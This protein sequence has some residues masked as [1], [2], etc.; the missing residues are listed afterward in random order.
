MGFGKKFINSLY[1]FKA[2]NVFFNHSV[3]KG[4]LYLFLLCLCLSTIGN[5]FAGFRI[6]TA[7]NTAQDTI[8]NNMPDF[9]FNNG[10][11]SVDGEMPIVIHENKTIFYI[12]TE[13]DVD[14]S[15]L[16]NYSDGILLTKDK[17]IQKQNNVQIQ[18]LDLKQMQSFSFNK[19]DISPAL[20]GIKTFIII[21]RFIFYPL[22][23]FIGKLASSFV[24]MG[25]GGLILNA[26]LNKKLKYMDCVKLGMYSLTV[27][28][29]LNVIKGIIG[30]Q[31]S[32]FFI[33]YYG[34]ALLYLFLGMKEIE[35]T[36]N[37]N[38]PYEQIN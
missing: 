10:Q 31:I 38:N 27:P 23:S 32:Y 16:D 20:K 35:E 19:A 8:D 4:I 12:D 14:P 34:I 33:L 26:I 28:I 13:N 3:G 2:Y 15:V 1:N 6:N 7:L 11:L 29:I 21:L 17:M 25:L 5:I 24:I 18:T 37:F 30:I 9:S 22:F 36:P